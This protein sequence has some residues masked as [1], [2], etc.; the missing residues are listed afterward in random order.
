MWIYKIPTSFE[1]NPHKKGSEPVGQIDRNAVWVDDLG[2]D[3]W[4]ALWPVQLGPLHPG[5]SWSP[6]S[7]EHQACNQTRNF[8]LRLFR[9]S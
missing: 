1:T 8:I 9:F 6:L 4:A 5:R 3:E 7:E 2:G